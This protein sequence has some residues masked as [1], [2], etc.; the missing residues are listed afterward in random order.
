MTRLRRPKRQATESQLAQDH[1]P[2]F[3][4]HRPEVD[5]RG[6]SGSSS[7][8]R[9]TFVRSRVA[10]FGTAVARKDSYQAWGLPRN[11]HRSLIYIKVRR[12]IS[13]YRQTRER[14]FTGKPS[15]DAVAG[16]CRS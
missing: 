3:Q 2:F 13:Y 16:E 8:I 7:V 11:H 5:A 15:I 10:A 6:A 14:A 4:R 9:Q 1:E 12:R